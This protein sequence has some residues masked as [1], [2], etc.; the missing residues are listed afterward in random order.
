MTATPEGYH[1]EYA[2]VLVIYDL[3]DP[4][5]WQRAIREQ[6]SWPREHR[7]LHSL[8]PDHI[9]LELLPGALSGKSEEGAA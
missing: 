9:V 6:Q 5:V 2:S 8:G 7:R 4:E 3:G 1:G